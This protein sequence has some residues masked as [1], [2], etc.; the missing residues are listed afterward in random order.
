MSKKIKNKDFIEKLQEMFPEARWELNYETPFQLLC[1]VMWS[2]QTTDIQV[3]KATSKFFNEYKEPLD[4]IYL[5]EEG[6]RER[7]KT[8]W[9][10]RWKAKNTLATAEILVNKYNSEVP[11]TIEELIELPWV[12]V[13][14]AKV[15]L[16]ELYWKPY[17]AV[18]THVHRTLNRL[19]LVNTKYPDQTDKLVDKIFTEEEIW[20]LHHLL[21]FFWRYLCKS[22]KP[23]CEKCPFQWYCKFY[24]QKTPK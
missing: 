7:I 4:A 16:L 15:V 21:I 3:N 10:N 6:I 24:K 23:E 9:L 22:Q 20:K 17:L 5:W 1:A 12:W 11:S 14:T 13:K 18:D 19:W 2:A 8:I